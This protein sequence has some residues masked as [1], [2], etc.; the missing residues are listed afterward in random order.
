MKGMFLFIEFREL[1]AKV[2]DLVKGN[3]G[4]FVVPTGYDWVGVDC[5]GNFN[6]CGDGSQ[7]VTWYYDRIRDKLNPSQ[8]M[9]IVPDGSS[10]SNPPS[11]EELVSR[12]EKYLALAQS[13][14]SFVGAF[15]FL[16]Q[17]FSN[18]TGTRDL[19]IVKEKYKQVGGSIIREP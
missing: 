9:I 11:Q 3:Y 15:T 16:W 12:A 6:S 10:V 13:D 19:P 2:F 4:A 1:L 18:I 8:R 14:P 5:Y 7:S 17:S